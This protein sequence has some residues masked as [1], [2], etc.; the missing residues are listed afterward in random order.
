M[1]DFEKIKN[2]CWAKSNNGYIFSRDENSKIIYL[3]RIVMNASVDEVVDHQK[4]NLM[5]NRKQFL[6]IGTQSNNNMNHD[7]R[8]DNTSGI[9]GVWL[10]KRN[11]HWCSEIMLNKKKIHLGSFKTLEE[12]AQARRNAEEKYFQEWSFKNSTGK[13]N[14]E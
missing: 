14:N 3:H 7:M 2:Y 6:R 1:E 12:A 5:D 4:H 10:D 13:Y 8:S 11:N 9:T